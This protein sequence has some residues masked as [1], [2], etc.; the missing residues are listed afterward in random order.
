MRVNCQA[1]IPSQADSD[2]SSTVVKL[3]K[4]AIGMIFTEMSD[5]YYG[6]MM[7]I[8]MMAINMIDYD[9]KEI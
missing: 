6:T 1:P 3:V 4:M 8:A 2:F 7:I 5:E 9:S